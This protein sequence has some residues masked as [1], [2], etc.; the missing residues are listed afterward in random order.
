MTGT[1]HGEARSAVRIS[2]AHHT[3]L[4]MP[5]RDYTGHEMH[6]HGLTASEKSHL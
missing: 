6:P 5:L 2:L 4:L 1:T 3:V